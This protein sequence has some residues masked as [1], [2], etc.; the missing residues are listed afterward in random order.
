MVSIMHLE[1]RSIHAL[2][3]MTVTSVRLKTES[4]FQNYFNLNHL[5]ELSLY[6]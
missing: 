4:N 2:T 5:M 3:I 6:T 1:T